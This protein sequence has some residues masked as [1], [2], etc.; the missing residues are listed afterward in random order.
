MEKNILNLLPY[1]KNLTPSIQSKNLKF[2]LALLSGV[3]LLPIQLTR[4]EQINLRC[5]G[6]YEINRGPL[7]KPDWEMSYLKIN[8]DG[9]I[10][11]IDENGTKKEGRTLLRRNSYI[12]THRDTRKRIKNIYKINVKYGTYTVESTQR[13]RTLFGTC[14]KGR[15]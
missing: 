15:G 3:F 7:I 10:S 1:L 6:K 13:N 2:L 14:Q 8:T 4:S 9:L 11:T 12:I 5:I